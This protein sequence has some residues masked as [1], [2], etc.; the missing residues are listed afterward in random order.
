VLYRCGVLLAV[1]AE[2]QRIFPHMQHPS[3]H[4]LV[5]AQATASTGVAVSP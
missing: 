2:A 5:L 3:A 1:N 4:E